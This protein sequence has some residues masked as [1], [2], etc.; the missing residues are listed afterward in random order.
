MRPYQT[1]EEGANATSNSH[2]KLARLH[3]PSRMAGKSFLDIGCSEGFFCNVARQRGAE[4]VVGIDVKTP[5]LELARSLYGGDGMEFREQSWASLPGGPFDVILLASAL[6]Y[7]R[8]PGALIDRVADA[9]SPDGV[10]VLELG[11]APLSSREMILV[12]RRR[13]DVWVPTEPYL[14]E[15]LLRRFA[16]RRVAKPQIVSGDP[17]PR[18]VYHCTLRRPT[19][20]LLRGPSKQGKST[21]ARLF[22]GQSE[23][24]ISVDRFMV[25]LMVSAFPHDDF[26][27]FMVAN[28]ERRLANTYADI[29]AQGWTDAFAQLLSLAVAPSD[30]RVIIEGFLSDLQA[31]A[32]VKALGSRAIVWDA[33]RRMEGM[34]GA[35][36]ADL[37]DGFDAADEEDSEEEVLGELE[38]AQKAAKRRRLES[39]AEPGE[40]SRA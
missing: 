11:V 34:E 10:F 38:P 28:R 20:L 18:S 31:T 1:H 8:D 40:P 21:A 12:Q 17:T 35:D 4:R 15:V 32:L 13:L 16:C 7:E 36:A 30:D 9:L 3:L 23:K 6:H 19:V 37:A 29:D 22:G 24:T 2:R 26:Q 14:L 25:R 27:R 33:T 5:S 39:A